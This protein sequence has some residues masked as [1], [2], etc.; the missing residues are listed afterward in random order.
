ML[1]GVLV[2]SDGGV[3]RLGVTSIGT[4]VGWGVTLALDPLG[5]GIG[6]G[7][8]RL[9]VLIGTDGGVETR[10]VTSVEDGDGILLVGEGNCWTGRNGRVRR[11]RSDERRSHIRLVST[12][13]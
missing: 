6:G 1:L 8:S 3:E 7:I 13:I 5:A 10:G 12:T 2:G 4:G 9:G 11:S